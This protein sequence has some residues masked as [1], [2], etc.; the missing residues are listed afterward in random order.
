MNKIVVLSIGLI[1]LAVNIFSPIIAVLFFS[2]SPLSVLMGKKVIAGQEIVTNSYICH[3]G[4]E[5]KSGSDKYVNKLG[6]GGSGH[7][8]HT[9]QPSQE[10]ASHDMHQQNN[11]SHDMH[12]QHHQMSD[13]MMHDNHSVPNEDNSSNDTQNCMIEQ[14]TQF[15]KHHQY[16]FNPFIPIIFFL[17]SSLSLVFFCRKN[18]FIPCRQRFYL[19]PCRQAP[20]YGF[21]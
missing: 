11:T 12:S 9:P 2:V 15:F 20:P 3:M 4:I 17:L 13:E 16:K 6:F 10:R 21:C 18:I 19:I 8:N 7:K 1:A 14:I 5:W